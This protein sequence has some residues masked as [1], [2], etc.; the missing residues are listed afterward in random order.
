MCSI[1]TDFK[2]QILTAHE[3]LNNL[4]EIAKTIDQ[5]HYDKVN[6][7]LLKAIEKEKIDKAL[8]EWLLE[9]ND[10]GEQ[11]YIQPYD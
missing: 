9:Y 8:L 5:T 3:A 7:M 11:D 1:C 4:P 2:K 6:K 10:P